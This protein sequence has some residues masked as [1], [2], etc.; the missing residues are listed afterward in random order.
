[1]KSLIV[2]SLFLFF[3]SASHAQAK[4]LPEFQFTRMDNGAPFTKAGI[5]KGKKSL[6]LFFDTECIHCRNAIVAY[7][8]DE[9]KLKDD[10]VSVYLVTKDKKDHALYFLRT[11]A[12]RLS[13]RKNVTFLSDERN[14]FITRF[15]PMKYPSMFLYGKDQK[16]IR[17]S[18]EEKDIPSFIVYLSK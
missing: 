4:T 2:S 16:L 7:N 17:Y 12:P 9:A 8:K 18:D 5:A 1:M 11:Y 3:A 15:Q 6:I 10:L 14:E 13:K